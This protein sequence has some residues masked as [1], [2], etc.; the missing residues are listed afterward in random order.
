MASPLVQPCPEACAK[1]CA[2][3]AKV[4]MFRE[5][6]ALA[7]AVYKPFGERSVP[8]YEEVTDPDELA[9]LDIHPSKLHPNGADLQ[10]MGYLTPQQAAKF[11]D[12]DFRAAVFRKTGTNDYKIAFKGTESG[13]DWMQ[14]LSQGATSRANYYTRAQEIGR[15]AGANAGRGGVGNV[16]FVGH[17]LGGGLASGA[18]HA[19]GLPATTFNSAGLHWFNRS[20]FNAPPV[21]AVRV[22]GELL[23]SLQGAVPVAP[24]AVGSPYRIKAPSTVARTLP[25]A[26]LDGWDA[27]VPG[28]GLY[29]YG[30]AA[31]GR[32][33]ELHKMPAV[34]SA[35]SEHHVGLQQKAQA[36]G[37]SC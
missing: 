3:I 31:V 22:D 10:R 14:N 4:E 5:E 37:C 12:S 21:D 8:G 1:I 25:R 29:K 27:V 24:E 32:A 34:N 16:K 23:T 30:K 2:E 17:S 13:A 26:N 6:A 19:A 7:S 20:W 36:Q 9:K 35:L 28:R 15:K 18:A 11:K 33:V